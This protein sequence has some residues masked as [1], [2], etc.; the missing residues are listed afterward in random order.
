MTLAEFKWKP[1][2]EEVLLTPILFH[3]SRLVDSPG[4][5]G[6]LPASVAHTWC[7]E[8]QCRLVA[9]QSSNLFLSF[10]PR[11][12]E[13]PS[14]QDVSRTYKGVQESNRGCQGET[15]KVRSSVLMIRAHKQTHHLRCL[16]SRKLISMCIK[17]KVAARCTNGMLSL[18]PSWCYYVHIIPLSGNIFNV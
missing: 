18:H 5:R 11:F 17:H 8:L 2:A 12:G 6:G 3:L 16:C 15:R 9:G 7:R 4:P 10:A 14:R 13:A 1:G